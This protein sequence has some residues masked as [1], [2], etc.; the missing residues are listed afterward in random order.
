MRTSL[1]KQSAGTAE[2]AKWVKGLSL[3][4]EALYWSSAAME[5]AWHVREYLESHSG[6]GAGDRGFLQLDNQ[7]ASQLVS[8]GF[9]LKIL[10]VDKHQRKTVGIAVFP[11]H[12]HT[13]A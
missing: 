6:M 2:R 4:H 3:R 5:E 13:L 8:S 7:L 11:L 1:Q 9:S 10:K 12:V